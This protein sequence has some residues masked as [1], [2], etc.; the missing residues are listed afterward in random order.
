MSENYPFTGAGNLFRF[1]QGLVQIKIQNKVVVIFDNDAVGLDA[2]SK[3]KQLRLP[4]NMLVVR[5]PD[6][7]ECRLFRTNGPNGFSQENIN[8]RAVSIDP[9]FLYELS[10]ATF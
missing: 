10:A 3:V 9:D 6:L 5:L 1:C 2:Q 4:S 8:G 7:P